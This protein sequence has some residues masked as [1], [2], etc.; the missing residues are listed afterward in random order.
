MGKYKQLVEDH[1]QARLARNQEASNA[2]G[3]LR[4][5]VE[6]IL[7]NGDSDPDAT[8][9]AA[10]K[11]MVK[12]LETVGGEQSQ[13]EIEILEPYLP[14]TLTEDQIKAELDTL[15]LGSKPNV[16]AKMGAAMKHLKGRAD[17]NDVKKVV[18]KHY[19]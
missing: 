17:G 7:K 6:T 13:R 12:G 3:T 8:T 19:N 4:G 18:L 10:A 11:K 1:K 16:G 15:D 9:E 14:Q 5:E 2:L